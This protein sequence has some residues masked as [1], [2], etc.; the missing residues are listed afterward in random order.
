[1][2]HALKPAIPV[3][4]RVDESG[5]SVVSV[6]GPA[7]KQMV[8][9]QPSRVALDTLAELDS[10]LQPQPLASARDFV[11]ALGG[12]DGAGSPADRD[13][14]LKALMSIGALI[15]L[16]DQAGVALLQPNHP[17]SREASHWSIYASRTSEVAT[18]FQRL[19]KAR[20]CVVGVG[21][22]GGTMATLLARAGVQRLVL[23]DGDLVEESNLNRQLLFGR[24]DVG[25]L[26][27]TA[28]A[29]A[30]AAVRANVELDVID[31]PVTSAAALATAIGG[32]SVAVLSAD[33]PAGVVTEWAHLAAR[34]VGVPILP[35]GYTL[36][37][38]R[39]G[40]WIEGDNDG[41]IP[42]RGIPAR[43]VR[44][45]GISPSEAATCTA[46]SAIA[47]YEVLWRV[48]MPHSTRN[49]PRSGLV[50]DFAAQ[51]LT[52]RE[53]TAVP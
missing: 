17:L 49:E 29:A 30:L 25:R 1:M 47:A 5:A 11:A 19:A 2:N 20:V 9:R 12:G 10:A 39:V 35:V 45:G 16:D 24:A 32:S 44:R 40:P 22:I 7:G 50:L 42:A 3:T 41:G 21:G 46:A 6:L 37:S 8:L 26:K 38:G 27:V 13:F 43:G 51:E 28:V 48:G 52:K 36:L 18:F 15:E 31:R 14:L 4:L 34:S 53:A 23:V 33:E